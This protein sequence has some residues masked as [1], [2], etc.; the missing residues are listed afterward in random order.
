MPGRHCLVAVDRANPHVPIGFVSVLV[1]A[2]SPNV[3]D[4]AAGRE[5]LDYLV[6]SYLA[7]KSLVQPRKGVSSFRESSPRL[8]I[9][10]LGVAPQY[11]NSGLARSLVL[12]MVRRVRAS[13]PK[14]S[15]EHRVCQWSLSFI[16][17]T[18]FSISQDLTLGTHSAYGNVTGRSPPSPQSPVTPATPAEGSGSYFMSTSIESASKKLARHAGEGPLVIYANVATMNIPAISF[19]E[20]MG[21]FVIPEVKLKGLYRGQGSASRLLSN[22]SFRSDGEGA[23]DAFVVAGIM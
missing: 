4:R 5:E 1:H 17:L 12:E 6:D 22:E 10:T 11:Q 7:S 16:S 14:S 8:E 21:L 19:Y 18:D 13:L 3:E 2:A 20:R 9:L 23:K 15:G